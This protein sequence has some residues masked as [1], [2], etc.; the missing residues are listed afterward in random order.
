MASIVRLS[1]ALGLL[2]LLGPRREEWL[3]VPP[4][5]VRQRSELHMTGTERTTEKKDVKEDR[6]DGQRS[7]EI[8]SATSTLKGGGERLFS[9]QNPPILFREITYEKHF[10]IGCS[11]DAT[12]EGLLATVEFYNDPLPPPTTTPSVEVWYPIVGHLEYIE[13]GPQLKR[14]LMNHIYEIGGNSQSQSL[15]LK[16]D[17]GK[18]SGPITFYMGV[19]LTQAERMRELADKFGIVTLNLHLYF[20][21]LYNAGTLRQK[22]F[23]YHPVFPFDVTK[24]QMQDWIA[25]WTGWHARSEDLPGSVPKSVLDDYVEATSTFNI[26][27]FRA[28]SVMARRA[29]QQALEDKGATKGS[30]LA[31]QVSELERKGLLSSATSSLAHGVR[32]FGN[33]GAH[34]NDDLLTQVTSDEARLALDVTKKILK[35]LYK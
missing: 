25:R 9:V 17:P 16:I 7:I 3:D 18:T 33:F 10:K 29:L 23:G 13:Q 24:V 32:Q 27:A 8:G 20:S 6:R 34:P 28:S 19:A 30:N 5:L 31:D 12:A 26:N 15:D 35:E 22:T 14:V 4:L 21:V 11:L 2:A 1:S